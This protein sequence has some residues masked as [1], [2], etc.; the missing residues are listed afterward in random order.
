MNRLYVVETT[1]TN[2]GAKADHRL[3]LR[4]QEIE[5]FARA[6]AAK[7]GRIRRCRA[8]AV[9]AGHE[10]WIDAVAKDLQ[11]HR[12]RCVVLAG[13]RQPP[14]VHLLAH[15][16]NERLGNVGQTVLHTDP[17]RNGPVDQLESLRELVEDM[18]GGQVEMLVILGGNPGVHRAGRLPL[19]RVA[20]RRCRSAST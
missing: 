14:V 8:G 17:D 4:A 9:P 19:R 3:A 15:A 10:N 2:T 18:D 16:L 12:G 6:V 20:C 7:L 13:D 1:V 5:G 11:Q